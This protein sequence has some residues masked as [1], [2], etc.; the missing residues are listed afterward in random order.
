MKKVKMKITELLNKF[1]L[2]KIEIGDKNIRIRYNLSSSQYFN[3]DGD[4]LELSEGQLDVLEKTHQNKIIE[5]SIMNEYKN[6]YVS[7]YDKKE[8]YTI[9]IWIKEGEH[10]RESLY[11]G[12]LDFKNIDFAKFESIAVEAKKNN[13]FVCSKCNNLV[14]REQVEEFIFSG[15][16][17]KECTEKYLEVRNI[18]TQSRKPYFYD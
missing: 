6:L 8:E 13:K 11:S 10:T 7:V 3:I 9:N 15:V 14:R 16:Y 5:T 1:Y 18:V 17:C 4:E 2:F 12:A